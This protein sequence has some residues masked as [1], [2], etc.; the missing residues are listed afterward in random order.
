MGL[1]L[2]VSLMPSRKYQRKNPSGNIA[3]YSCTRSNFHTFRQEFEHA[4]S[5]A[6]FFNH[7]I[8]KRGS[9]SYMYTCIHLLFSPLCGFNYAN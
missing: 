6:A 3:H 8:Q 7:A 1:L 9:V 2:D 5:N 4:N